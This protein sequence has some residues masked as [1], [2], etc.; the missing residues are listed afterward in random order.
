MRPTG[1]WRPKGFLEPLIGSYLRLADETLLVPVALEATE[2]E[3]LSV[4]LFRGVAI[5]RATSAS[6]RWSLIATVAL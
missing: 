3:G 4:S 5:A 1:N 6:A 2:Q